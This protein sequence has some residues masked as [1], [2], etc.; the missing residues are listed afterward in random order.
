MI[1]MMEGSLHLLIVKQDIFINP[2]SWSWFQ[3]SINEIKKSLK[4][5]WKYSQNLNKYIYANTY[6]HMRIYAGY[7]LLL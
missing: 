6:K 7:M 1:K 2:E 3:L 5:S 4:I